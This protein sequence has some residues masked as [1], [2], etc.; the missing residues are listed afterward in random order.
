MKRLTVTPDMQAK[1]NAVAGTEVDPASIAVYESIAVTKAPIQKPRNLYDG[2]TFDPG[3]FGE[4][5]AFLSSGKSVF[6]APIHNTE[7]LPLGRV[8]NAWETGEGLRAQFYLPMTSGDLVPKID[9]GVIKNVSIGALP[10]QLLCSECSW[11]YMGKDASIM[12]ILDKTCENDHTIGEN[13][14][15]VVSKGLDTWFELSLVGTGAS[16]GAEILARSKAQLAND[17]SASLVRLAANQVPPE[18]VMLVTTPTGDID[19]DAK[20]IAA[21]LKAEFTTSLAENATKIATLEAKASGL[22]T[23]VGSLQTQLTA[24]N[25]ALEAANTAKT[26]AEAKAVTLEAT[27]TQ[28][29]PVGDFIKEQAEKAIIASNGK[30]ES[31]PKEYSGM[32]ETIKNSGM[33]LAQIVAGQHSEPADAA[34]NKNAH[35]SND[36]FKTRP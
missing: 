19:M 16:P 1:I 33:H 29:K 26:N 10:K 9:T 30:P 4:M 7:Q 27:V 11:D 13:G 35:V 6:V 20:E 14:V 3:F 8:F 17:N 15:H 28:L 24:A 34:K 18:A 25:T 5:A 2:G 22:E 21:Q 36:A 32:I 31:L 12:N 23:Q